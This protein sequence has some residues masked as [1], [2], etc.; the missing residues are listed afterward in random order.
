MFSRASYN[1][2]GSYI[3]EFDLEEG[4]IDKRVVICFEGVEQAAYVWL[5]GHF[6]GYAEDSFRRSLI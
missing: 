4:L 6:I 5:N 1:P 2:V 3:R